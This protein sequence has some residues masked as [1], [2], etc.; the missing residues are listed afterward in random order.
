[1]FGT[2]STPI[3]E[4]QMAKKMEHELE[5]LGPL[6]GV[7]RDPTPIMENPMEKNIEIG[8]VGL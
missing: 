7:C 6:K 5:T 2:Y 1:M 3:M 8:V 4:N